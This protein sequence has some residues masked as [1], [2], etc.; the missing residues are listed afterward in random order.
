MRRAVRLSVLAV[1]LLVCPVLGGGPKDGKFQER[2]SEG[3]VTLT[4]TLAKGK[5]QG[6]VVYHEMGKPVRRMTFDAGV[7]KYDR[8]LDEIRTTLRVLAAPT[9]DEHEAAL[10]VLKA[11]RYLCRLPYDDLALDKDYT[12]YAQAA[13]K[14][15]KELGRLD[16]RPKNPGWPQEEFDVAF[17]G[18]S[19]S[20]LGQGFPTLRAAVHGWMHDSDKFNID[21]LGHRRWCIRPAIKKLGFGRA[22]DFTAMYCF[23]MSRTKIPAYDYVAYPPSGYMPTSFFA[24]RRAW[25]VSFNPARFEVPKEGVEASLYPLDA[26]GR[27]KEPLK[28]DYFNVDFI[29]F[30]IPNC[31][32]FRPEKLDMTPGRRYLVEISGIRN[33]SGKTTIRYVVEMASGGPAS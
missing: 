17:K 8:P 30:G 33:K 20:S 6:E 5:L 16:H 32:V 24:P 25:N 11:Y 18:T 22:G 28:L 26:L 27:K 21:R 9:K 3:N 10:G 29:P 23:D 1:L 4:G 2:D 13:V 12:S 14:L 15:C 19:S 31:V 7:P